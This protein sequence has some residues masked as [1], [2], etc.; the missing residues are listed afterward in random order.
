MYKILQTFS[1]EENATVYIVVNRITNK[2]EGRFLSKA[3]AKA[4][5][6]SK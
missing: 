3:T 4:Y 2:V 5:I 6:L 1:N